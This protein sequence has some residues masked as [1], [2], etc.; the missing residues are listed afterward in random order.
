MPIEM[1]NKVLFTDQEIINLKG[2]IEGLERFQNAREEEE[3]KT[4][5]RKIVITLDIHILSILEQHSRET[6]TSVN[7]IINTIL[8]NKFIHK[9]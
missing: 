6:N 1:Q 9:D 8:E 4:G 2:F 7:N 3:Q 5:K